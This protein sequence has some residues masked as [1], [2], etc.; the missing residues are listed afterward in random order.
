VLSS[1]DHV[2]AAPDRTQQKGQTQ[3][4]VIARQLLK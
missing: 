1:F 4:M 3:R 2:S